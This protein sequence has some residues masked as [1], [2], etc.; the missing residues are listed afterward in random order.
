MIASPVLTRRKVCSFI[1]H[2]KGV[3]EKGV[4]VTVL[5]LAAGRY[6]KNLA[7]SAERSAAML[8]ESG[9]YVK[10]QDAMHDRFAVIDG[11]IVWYGS[12]NLLAGEKTDDNIM[13]V[14]DTEIAQELIER[15]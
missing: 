9:I 12:M 3:Q 15:Y 1:D 13:R 4:R 2:I 6:R 14:A 8:R 5:T 11:K 10:P 7:A